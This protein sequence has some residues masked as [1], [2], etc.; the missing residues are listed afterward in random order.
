MKNQEKRIS[1]KT[2]RELLSRLEERTSEYKEIKFFEFG[3]WSSVVARAAYFLGV[4]P[5]R[6]LVPV[7]VILA[8]IL[9]LIFREKLVYLVS[10]F[11][12]GF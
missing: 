10:I 7:A 3:K 11:Q 4:N 12:R 2:E 6:V 5:M 9:V 8:M 1:S